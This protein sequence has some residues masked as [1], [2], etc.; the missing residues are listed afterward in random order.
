M[1]AFIIERPQPTVELFDLLRLDE[2]MPHV[3]QVT[4]SQ[5]Y[6]Q[7]DAKMRIFFAIIAGTHTYLLS[8]AI[9]KIKINSLNF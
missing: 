1:R 3:G 6:R 9:N 8:L 7:D 2:F 5:M 4:L